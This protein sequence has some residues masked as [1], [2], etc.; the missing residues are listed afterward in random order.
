MTHWANAFRW[1]TIVIWLLA[2]IPF[3]VLLPEAHAQ[4]VS[5]VASGRQLARTSCSKCH[6]V[7]SK[8]DHGV[9]AGAPTFTAI[10]NRSLTSARSL[11]EFF[12]RPN[13]GM[14]DLHLSRVD[15]DSS[16]CLH[17][18]PAAQLNTRVAWA[19]QRMLTVPAAPFDGDQAAVL[20]L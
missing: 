1:M 10:A 11:R 14:Q 4:K 2:T 9:V 3:A 13:Y 12:E 19:R 18:E 15:I 8:S 7:T 5:D 17:P 6:L 16:F 20:C